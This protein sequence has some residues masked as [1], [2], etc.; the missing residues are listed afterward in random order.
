M[1]GASHGQYWNYSNVL[2]GQLSGAPNDAI[3]GG[4][5]EAERFAYFGPPQHGDPSK[6]RF[7]DVSRA[8]SIFPEAWGGIN[9]RDGGVNNNWIEDII[10]CSISNTDRPLLSE[11]MPILRVEHGDVQFLVKQLLFNTHHLDNVPELGIPRLVESR[12]RQ[13]QV[14]GV[15]KGIGFMMESGYAMTPQGKRDYIM[16]IAQI[17]I[18]THLTMERDAYFRLLTA[19]TQGVPRPEFWQYMGAP[20]GMGATVE[21]MLDFEAQLWGAVSKGP[22]GWLTIRQH[23]LK[24]GKRRSVKLDTVIVPNGTKAVIGNDPFFR[25]YSNVGPTVERAYKSPEGN[26]ELMNTPDL[27]VIEADLYHA[28]S[29]AEYA[30]EDPLVR[31]RTMGTFFP[32][33]ASRYY[34]LFDAIPDPGAGHRPTNET[35]LEAWYPG[36]CTA[37]GIAYRSDWLDIKVHSNETD[38]MA[39]I[40]FRD[41]VANCPFDAQFKT[42]LAGSNP[43]RGANDIG[44]VLDS[45]GFTDAAP[46]RHYRV[47]V[48]L[49][50]A[51]RAMPGSSDADLAGFRIF[52]NACLQY[53]VPPP[54]DILV[55][56]PLEAW[57]MG[58]AIFCIRG[59]TGYSAIGQQ[60]FR[61]GD[62]PTRKFLLGT[63]TARTAAVVMHPQNVE[64]AHNI[65]YRNYVSGGGT[66]FWN[67]EDPSRVF[68]YQDPSQPQA[69]LI[70]CLVHP[71]DQLSA[72]RH[73]DGTGKW[74]TGNPNA[75][76]HFTTATA[77]QSHWKIPPHS[78]HNYFDNDY[79]DGGLDLSIRGCRMSRGHYLVTPAH[80]Q[81][82]GQCFTA[83]VTGCGAH[84]MYT[85]PGCKADRMGHGTHSHVLTDP[86]PYTTM[87]DA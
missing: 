41:A 40:K 6:N 30:T 19:P 59:R 69:D 86:I 60:D 68:S 84:G 38:S 83:K 58:S 50:L 78:T 42:L 52:M 71:V 26:F 21:Q 54:F 81:K 87:P 14:K 85:Y 7:G 13:W 5:K 49:G 53:N 51:W 79:F 70:A 57:E 10:I 16:S 3:N 1:E 22:H 29:E 11:I 20:L 47:P 43:H 24:A 66:Q 25:T 8:Y 56:R 35:E 80:T 73:I 32:M 48:A 45:M 55:Q 62:D 28:Y 44:D 27:R 37:A 65:A 34:S 67:P 31:T 61:I 36:A 63:F 75:E 46:D 82:G 15:R 39:T 18:A 12:S 17:T 77:N 2:G 23:I 64:I 33:E 74:D 4:S 9:A 76:P 72:K